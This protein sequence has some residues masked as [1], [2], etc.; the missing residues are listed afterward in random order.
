MKKIIPLTLLLICASL[1]FAAFQMNG[2]PR[3]NKQHAP[4]DV[5]TRAF[6]TYLTKL[7]HEAP[8]TGHRK[9][10]ILTE[11]GCMGC[12]RQV[13]DEWHAI[14]HHEYQVS[15]IIVYLNQSRPSKFD[16]IHD[17]DEHHVIVDHS[18]QLSGYNIGITTD[19]L[20]EME[21]GIVTSSETI[22]KS[23]IDDIFNRLGIGTPI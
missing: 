18:N 5:T 19:G 11:D 23:N 8:E 2:T 9:Y 7:G 21:E 15:T 16:H 13:C 1:V 20:V 12:S 17:S 10:L 3:V 14:D 22:N 6:R 4:D